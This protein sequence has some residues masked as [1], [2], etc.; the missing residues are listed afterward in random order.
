MLLAA[1]V[2]ADGEALAAVASG[3][4]D[5]Q[6]L[7]AVTTA[8]RLAPLVLRSLQTLPEA[9]VPAAV[10]ERL[11]QK[12][13]KN[14]RHSIRMLL[15]QQRIMASF[16]ARGFALTAL[17][18]ATLAALVYGDATVRHS[19]DLDL[20]TREEKLTEQITL[21]EDLGYR[22]IDPPARL[23]PRRLSA[24]ARYWKGVTLEHLQTGLVVDLHW[25]L[26]DHR[27]HPANTLVTAF[28]K[29]QVEVHGV[30]VEA[31]PLEIQFIYSAAHGAWD[32]WVHLKGLADVAA[33]P[34]RMTPAEFS[35]ALAVAAEL[36][37]LD[38]VSSAVHLAREWFG[39]TVNSPLLLSPENPFHTAIRA[40][41][42][43][44]MER[45]NY[46]P[47]RRRAGTVVAARAEWRLLP[48][49]RSAGQMLGRYLWRPRVWTLLDLPEPLTGLYPLL[50][51]L[52]PPRL[53]AAERSEP[54]KLAR[55]AATRER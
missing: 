29:T 25:R 2:D 40:R 42:L 16:S 45:W 50:G 11:K 39:V 10:L 55:P 32:G 33:A 22:V 14:R 4:I 41:L 37:L 26:F 46:R 8:H 28:P 30:R 54:L 27:L 7:L 1:R 47:H 24:Y 52:L 51:A 49:S 6:E 19:G 13:E 23:T 12:V 38:Q 31:L 5:W 34:C 9:L 44:E 3:G 35:R 17:K 15:E 20:L 53:L 36:G 48:G 43:S 18:G 21:L